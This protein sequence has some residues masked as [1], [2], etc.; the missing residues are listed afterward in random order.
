MTTPLF[1]STLS[2]TIPK[3]IVTPNP[4]RGT[5]FPVHFPQIWEL[6]KKVEASFWTIDDIILENLA[7]R[8][9]NVV[10]VTEAH[11]FYNFEIADD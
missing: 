10:Q 11:A 8:F 7:S 2:I 5:I 4:S 3:P 6:Y 9:M 1:L